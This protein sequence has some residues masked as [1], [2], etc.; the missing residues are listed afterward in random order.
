MRKKM[1]ASLAIGVAVL[2]LFWFHTASHGAELRVEKQEILLLPENYLDGSFEVSEDGTAWAYITKA[3]G[4]QR[5]VTAGQEGKVFSKCSSPSFSP[6]TNRLFYWAMDES[7]GRQQIVLVEDAGTVPTDLAAEGVLSFSPDG[8]RWAAVGGMHQTSEGNSIK[9]GKVVVLCDGQV[10]GKYVDATYPSF[11]PDSKHIAYLALEGGHFDLIVDGKV[12]RTYQEPQVKTSFSVRAFSIG[13]N[14]PILFK[15]RYLNNDSLLVLTQDKSGWIVYRGATPLGAY[16]QN[17]WGGGPLRVMTF[18]EQKEEAS[19]LAYS[20]TC[21]QDAPVAVWWERLAGKD[22]R[23]RV[24][25]DGQPVDGIVATSFWDLEQPAISADGNH[26]AYPAYL[27][28]EGGSE[29]AIFVIMDGK[30]VGPYKNAW[31]LTLSAKGE[32]FVYAGSDGSEHRPWTFYSDGTPL[33]LKYDGVWLPEICSNGSHVIW[34]GR[35]DK[36]VYLALDGSEI[37]S[38]ET[39]L[40]GPGLDSSGNFWVVLGDGR[41]AVKIAVRGACPSPQAARGTPIGFKGMSLRGIGLRKTLVA[42]V[43][44]AAIIVIIIALIAVRRKRSRSR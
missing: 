44:L 33:G 28:A 4:G 1:T 24:V 17:V 9:L 15:G 29:E 6:V 43:C 40:G 27:K 30:K 35:R 41:R 11:S 7:L 21:A 3:D 13:P 36:K 5:I 2:C 34:V 37:D 25:R 22:E 20:L 12:E 14:M 31:G 19:I 23:W 16:L 8:K 26:V 38:S 32:R 18:S 39:R 42:I 10:L